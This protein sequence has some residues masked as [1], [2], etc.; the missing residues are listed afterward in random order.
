MKHV[1]HDFLAV[2]GKLFAWSDRQI[3]FQAHVVIS[4]LFSKI[5]SLKRNLKKN[6]KSTAGRSDGASFH[7]AHV[8][9]LCFED[10]LEFET[11]SQNN[12]RCIY[13]F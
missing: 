5:F 4:F 10:M 3:R 8:D 6:L 9:G 11:I 1:T 2:Y 13:E 7:A 12:N